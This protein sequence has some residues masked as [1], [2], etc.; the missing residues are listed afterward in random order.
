[1]KEDN[2]AYIGTLFGRVCRDVFLKCVATGGL[3]VAEFF[4]DGVLAKSMLA[5][6]FLIIFDWVT[7][8]L[9][10]KHTGITIK[11]SKIVRTPIKI[12]IYFMLIT[13]A[14][15]AEFSLPEVIRYLDEAVIAFLALTELIS[16]IENTGKL[17][18][19]IPKKLL[20]QLKSWRDEK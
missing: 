15:I 19:A 10:A 7:G 14:R 13:A 2:V 3:V 20:N 12:A 11:S 8:I 5:I 9:A 16:V 1:M 6:F 17:G 4:V 18:Y